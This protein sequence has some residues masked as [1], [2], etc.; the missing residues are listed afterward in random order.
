MSIT[1]NLTT[2]NDVLS[3]FDPVADEVDGTTI[4]RTWLVWKISDGFR[5]FDS[6]VVLISGS[7]PDIPDF[8]R[9]E[10]GSIT[11]EPAKSA[12]GQHQTVKFYMLNDI[13]LSGSSPN[14]FVYEWGTS[15]DVIPNNSLIS[16]AIRH[17]ISGSAAYYPFNSG[18]IT[19]D[20]N[21]SSGT[22]TSCM[23]KW[24]HA[25]STTTD[26]EDIPKVIFWKSDT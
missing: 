24:G 5:A 14:A 19:I 11:D 9:N 3:G 1:H 16:V 12:T 18:S 8:L 23:V 21:G 25:G 26:M 6:N 22:S 2:V 17:K 15:R 10:S 7:H 13:G 4:G 20:D